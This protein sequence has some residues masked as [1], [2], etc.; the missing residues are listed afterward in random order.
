MQWPSL[1]GWRPAW[2]P[3]WRSLWRWISRDRLRL[4]AFGGA[5][6]LVVLL[7]TVALYSSLALARVER[8]E[9]RRATFVYA[10]APPLVA[11]I[12]LRRV[13]PAGTPARLKDAA[14]HGA[15]ATPA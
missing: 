15:A 5:A 10:A 12:H 6:L 14:S 9:E 4:L 11:G 1:T 8:V 3:D 7:V 2:P 13:D